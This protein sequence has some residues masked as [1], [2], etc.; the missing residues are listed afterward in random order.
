MTQIIKLGALGGSG[1]VSTLIIAGIALKILQVSPDLGNFAI[2]SGIVI[3]IILGLLGVV[4][5]LSRVFRL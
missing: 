4:A 5:V 3:G 1:I 2:G